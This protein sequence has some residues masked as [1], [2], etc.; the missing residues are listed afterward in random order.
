M[1]IMQQEKQIIGM[2]QIGNS[3]SKNIMIN[4]TSSTSSHTCSYCGKAG[5]TEDI[6]YRK[7][8]FPSSSRRGGGSSLN[9]MSSYGRGMPDRGTKL[10]THYGRYGHTV[11]VCYRKH[12]F[13]PSHPSHKANQGA[14]TNNCEI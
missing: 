10:C 9:N 13:P 8:G 7:H 4:A 1:F 2:N 14:T 12:G 5:H 3:D 6:C 11:E